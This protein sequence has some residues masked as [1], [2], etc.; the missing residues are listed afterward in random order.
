MFLKLLTVLF[1]SL[2]YASVFRPFTP[3]R[4][5]RP[6]M[7]FDLDNT[8]YSR[9]VSEEETHR[10]AVEFIM[11]KTGCTPMQAELLISR[12]RAK[13]YPGF[14]SAIVKELGVD[15]GNEFE[16]YL[17]EKLNWSLSPNPKLRELLGS[18]NSNLYLM[19]SSGYG[20]STRALDT[21]GVR[22]LFNGVVHPD[23]K[24]PLAAQWPYEGVYGEAMGYVGESDPSNMYYV[25]DE[26][27]PAR[28]ARMAGWNSFYLNRGGVPTPGFPNFS[29]LNDIRRFAPRLF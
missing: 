11:S 2:A 7:F 12:Y 10:I 25:D 13:S 21:L 1:I 9:T 26:F 29:S 6:S 17:D 16:Q 8:L 18:M 3:R 19:S 22:D 5:G 20:K 27:G 14:M 28:N 4:N 23:F 24:N 15:T